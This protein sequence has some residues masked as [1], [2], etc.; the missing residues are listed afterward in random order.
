MIRGLL[1][2]V[3]GVGVG[4][5][6]MAAVQHQAGESVTPLS[7][8]DIAEKLDGKDA[9]A[10]VVEVTLQPGQAGAPHR[11]PGPVFGYVLE[12]QYELGIDDQPSRVLKA[13]ETFYEPTGCLHRV[14][15]NPAAT[16]KTRVL[17][18]VLHPR[19][20]KAVAIPEGKAH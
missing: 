16:G 12:G 10:T 1:I 17:A 9:R 3:A 15:K 11:H 13:G 5:A 8:R 6:G 20:A 19:D 18:V 14:S 7:A 4:V 2:L